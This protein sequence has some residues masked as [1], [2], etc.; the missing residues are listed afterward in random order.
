MTFA[1]NALE[2]GRTE[3]VE[4]VE[5]RLDAGVL[6]LCDHATNC[7]PAAYGRLGLPAAELQR[8]IAYDI[9]AAHITRRLARIFSAPAL[10]T[11][12]S[13]LLIDANRGADDPTLVMQL[14]DGNVIPGNAGISAAEIE[15]RR[16]LYWQPYRDAV[17]STIERM[18]ASCL[19]PAVLSVHSFTPSF[20][21]VVRPWQVGV[22][23]DSDAR[24][25][26]P[27]IEALGARGFV[28]GDNEPYDGALEGDTLDA[29][30]TTR[31][32]AGLL[33]EI[34]QDLLETEELAIAFAERL[35]EVL[36]PIL[37]RPE[38]HETKFHPSRTGRHRPPGVE[39]TIV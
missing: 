9:G 36:R 39:K 25:A 20:K 38:L 12:F 16:Q 14:A 29:E 8:H 23:W 6:F 5:G 21:G 34:R 15:N 19:V 27:L 30:I 35:A 2:F 4:Q 7:L 22:L 3:A 31:G 32:L 10:L 1:T 26:A 13:R 17:A 24:F 11:G 18:A 28:V 37:A 33:I